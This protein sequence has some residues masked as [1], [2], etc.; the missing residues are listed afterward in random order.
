MKGK[1]GGLRLPPG[2]RLTEDFPVLHMGRVPPFDEGT[3]DF[4]VEG[5]VE[6]P[7]RLTWPQFEALPRAVSV[8]DFHCVTGWSRFDNRWEGVLFQ[9][10]ADRVC[11]RPDA[12]FVTAFAESGYTTSLPLAEFMAEDVVLAYAH[13]GQPLRPEH[14]GP[15]RLVVPRTYAYKSVKWLR[16][17]R[18]TQEQELG[19]WEQRG[20]SNSADPWKEERYG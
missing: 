6:E 18:F 16:G 14:G 2:Q 19:Y 4:V 8:S 12:R 5:L 13:D 9:T 10:I 20:Y 7:L 3:W 17:L 11:P 15:L 1:E